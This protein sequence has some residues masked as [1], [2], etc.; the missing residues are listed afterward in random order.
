MKK[1][2]KYKRMND[3]ILLLDGHPGR[4]MLK[5]AFSLSRLLSI[6]WMVPCHHYPELMAE[7]DKVTHSTTKASYSLQ[8]FEAALEEEE[9]EGTMQHSF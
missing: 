6:L 8:T 9:E 7:Y 3:R 5:N 2:T 4:L 1:L